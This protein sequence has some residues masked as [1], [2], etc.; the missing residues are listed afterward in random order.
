MV[1]KG[2]AL[3]IYEEAHSGK[4]LGNVKVEDKLL[5]TLSQFLPEGC[6]P[7]IITD[8]GFRNPWFKQVLS[9]VWDFVGRVRGTHKYFD[10]KKWL[11]I[12]CNALYN[13]SIHVIR[14]LRSVE[15]HLL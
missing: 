1:S 14:E 12:K 11:S 15:L 7:I 4:M 5:D 3:T 2:R 6:K 8:A 10:G 9:L 13:G